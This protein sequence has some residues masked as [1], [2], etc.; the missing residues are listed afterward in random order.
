MKN[1]KFFAKAKEMRELSSPIY[2]KLPAIMV[3][4]ILPEGKIPLF[5]PS[6]CTNAG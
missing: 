4:M 6:V 1:I 3:I 5:L 2:K